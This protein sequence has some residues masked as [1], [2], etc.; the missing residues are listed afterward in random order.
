VQ[1]DPHMVVASPATPPRRRT[2]ARR[3]LGAPGS[4]VT[5]SRPNSRPALTP[6]VYTLAVIAAVQEDLLDR[7][8][9]LQRSG[10]PLPDPG[11]LADL[12][13]ANLPDT[14]AELDPHYADVG[15]FYGS[16]GAAQ[17]LGGITKQALSDRRKTPSVLAMRAGDGTWLYPAWQFS[18]AGAVHRVLAPVLREMAPVDRWAA[19]VWLVSDH[20]NLGG[21]S[22]RAALRD[23]EDPLRIAALAAVDAATLTA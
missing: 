22:P 17:Q 2:P 23:G 13:R 4:V 5:S 7:V 20:P 21:R 3:N 19:G 1:P 11:Q 9:R 6:Q 14:P 10:T 15:P 12:L 16:K 8:T 18:G